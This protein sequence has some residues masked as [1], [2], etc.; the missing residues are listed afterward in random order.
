MLGE[1]VLKSRHKDEINAMFNNGATAQQ[2]FDWLK[3]AVHG[4]PRFM[5]SVVSLQYY[6]KNF[7]KLSRMEINQR[8]NE[9]LSSGKT[10]DVTA[11]STFA[12]SK[13]Y[14]ESKTQEKNEV[15]KAIKEFKGYQEEITSAIKLLKEQT[16]DA[17]GKPVFIPR[18]YE[19][20]EKLVGRLESLNKN[21]IESYQKEN[22]KSK[23]TGMS[24]TTIN[25]NQMEQ[26]VDVVKN[27]VKRILLEIDPLKVARFWEI[28][29]EEAVKAS[30]RTGI[31][32]IKISINNQGGTDTNI[33][34]VTKLPTPEEVDL[35]NEA[36][37]SNENTTEH[38]V[39][40][41]PEPDGTEPPQSN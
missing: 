30:E 26:E 1:S 2:V 4:D 10:R 19:I 21:F 40:I 5:I 22:E 27:A 35:N 39:D 31:P 29:S 20:F 14:I 25:I 33:N 11:L 3:E 18:H 17:E 16:V 23:L 34:I 13:D 36:N 38:I 24:N 15:E 32:G 7:L 41:E 28:M 12:A 8:R 9:A 37:L 6:R